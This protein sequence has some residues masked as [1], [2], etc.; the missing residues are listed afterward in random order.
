[1]P[2][3]NT[4]ILLVE[5]DIQLSTLVQEY[6]QQQAMMVSIEHRGDKACQRIISETPDLVVVEYVQYSPQTIKKMNSK[7]FSLAT[8]P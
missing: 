6:L 2:E 8:I 1:M 7:W 5:D 4:R 3:A